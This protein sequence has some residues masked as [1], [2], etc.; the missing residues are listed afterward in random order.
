[1]ESARRSLPDTARIS[2]F[3]SLALMTLDEAILAAAQLLK[4]RGQLLNGHLLRLVDGDKELF[5][6]VRERLIDDGIA[7]DRSGVGLAPVA[8][9]AN[10]SR[11]SNAIGSTSSG[12]ATAPS[13]PSAALLSTVAEWW[14]MSSGA[15]HGPFTLATLCE[16]RRAGEVKPGDVVRC[17][18]K[19]Q[20]QQPDDVPDL[21]NAR[22]PESARPN[23]FR[24][25][26]RFLAEREAYRP[27][28]GNRIPSLQAPGKRGYV[29]PVEEF[30]SNP[31]TTSPKDDKNSKSAS[32]LPSGTD[33]EKDLGVTQTTPASS[34]TRRYVPPEKVLALASQ[35]QPGLLSRSWNIAADHAGGSNRLK[36]ILALCV[37]AGLL[38][39]WWRQP[40]AA[41]VIY[42][43]FTACRAAIMKLQDRRAKRSEWAPVVDQYRP[44]VQA[45]VNRLS[46]RATDRYRIQKELYSAGT[47]GLLPLL[48]N[49][50]DPTF[51]ERAFDQ[52]MANA[53]E[54]LDDNNTSKSIKPT[55]K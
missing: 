22:P 23:S 21:S 10:S 18:T 54:L 53:R 37:V 11:E 12:Q 9:Q 35:R 33:V 30:D 7:E 8:R 13:A 39:Y 48:E 19:G 5:R 29:A 26:E 25:G 42:D 40:P 38:I 24:I 49:P 41:R 51:A 27:T 43:E 47:Y 17:G 50:M 16:M 2:S 6:E 34:D 4:Q 44:R 45:I 20:W 52:H 55:N 36:V 14:L 1:M 31:A 15:V 3:N 28:A 32:S 46:S